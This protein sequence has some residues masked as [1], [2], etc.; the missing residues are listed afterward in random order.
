[1]ADSTMSDSRFNPFILDR[2]AIPTPG[3]IPAGCDERQSQTSTIP[4]FDRFQPQLSVLTGRITA[5]E[6]LSRFP[7]GASRLTRMPALDDHERRQHLDHGIVAASRALKTLADNSH[8]HLSVCVTVPWAWI[9]DAR[10]ITL[11]LQVVCDANVVPYNLVVQISDETPL[12]HMP[13]AIA[14]I[15]KL[16]LHGVEVCLS[17]F[18][19]ASHTHHHLRSLP[20]ASIRLDA[21]LVGARHGSLRDAVMVRS[22]IDMLRKMHIKV[23]VDGVND[24][25]DFAFVAQAQ[26]NVVQ[27]AF[28]TPPICLDL[29]SSWLNTTNRLAASRTPST[30][31]W[32]V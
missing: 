3:P 1:M 24:R 5:I 19:S 16:S 2:N 32:S 11:A 6:V 15:A 8:R 26:A 27:G 28:I 17:N 23:T 21:S 4:S 20:I 13:S 14:G 31:K 7:V 29:L 25:D 12:T 22:L 30:Q 18:G 10:A 9:E